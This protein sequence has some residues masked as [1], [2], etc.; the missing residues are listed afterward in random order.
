ML[1][2]RTPIFQDPLFLLFLHPKSQS[3]A[4]QVFQKA[5]EVGI[6]VVK[7][8]HFAHLVNALFRHPGYFQVELMPQYFL[9]SFQVFERVF[10]EE[11][12][13]LWLTDGCLF[14]VLLIE[15]L[16]YS[17]YHVEAF[18]GVIFAFLENPPQVVGSKA[19]SMT[20]QVYFSNLNFFHESNKIF[21]DV[22]KN[23]AFMFA[24]VF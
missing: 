5:L 2:T 22:M 13:E 23:G 19:S 1:L 16:C 4:F 15:A 14:E 24:V 7:V 3:S 21:V 20:G 8:I 10:A 12:L 17:E 11:S 18:F 6:E 9:G